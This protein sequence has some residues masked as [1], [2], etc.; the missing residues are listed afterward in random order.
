MYRPKPFVVDDVATLH[1]FM[2][3]RTFATLAAA[4]DGAACFAYAPMVLDA[5]DEQFGTLR[6]HLARANPL[7]ALPDGFSMRVSFTGPDAYIS[8]DWYESAAMVPTWNYIAVE[9]EGA[10]R[11]LDADGLRQLLVDLSAAEEEKLLPKQP[12]TIDKVPKERLSALMNA[13]VGF[14]LRLEML[15]GKF[16]LSQDKSAPDLDGALRGL[17]AREDAQSRA[18]AAAMRKARP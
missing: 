3:A 1:R 17:D 4:I 7:A 8:P 6:F 10:L 5:D 18:L 13:I 2:Q 9:G 11:R 16:K 14:S 12:W 15:E